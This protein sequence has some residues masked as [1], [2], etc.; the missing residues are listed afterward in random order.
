[1]GATRRTTRRPVVAITVNAS[2]RISFAAG[3]TMPLCACAQANSR[4]YYDAPNAP[5]ACCGL[6]SVN[7]RD[8]TETRTS[9][10]MLHFFH[11]NTPRIPQ[12]RQTSVLH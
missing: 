7:R 10:F 1:M 12:W 4:P 3:A 8:E 6:R 5:K 2:M 11:A 9:V